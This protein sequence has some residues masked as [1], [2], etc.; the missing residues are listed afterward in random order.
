MQNVLVC[1]NASLETRVLLCPFN[2]KTE[3]IYFS[4]VYEYVCLSVCLSVFVNH[5]H[6]GAYGGQKGALDPLELEL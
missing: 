3:I 6:M 5:I 2:L 4:R 1:G